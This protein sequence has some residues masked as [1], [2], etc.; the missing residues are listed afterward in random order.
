MWR[1]PDADVA[2]MWAG[3]SP[4]RRRGA[5]GGEPIQPAAPTWGH[6]VVRLQFGDDRLGDACAASPRPVPPVVLTGTPGALRRYSRVLQGH[7]TGTHGY[8]KGAPGG[9][10]R[11]LTGE[12][13]LAARVLVEEQR[14][15]RVRRRRGDG[16][17]LGRHPSHLAQWVWLRK[18]TADKGTKNRNKGTKNRNKGTKNRN[19]V[20][21]NAAYDY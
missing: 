11:V 19:K 15:H 6:L 2:Q 9:T 18:G 16:R 7:S 10:L 12:Q 20:A 17:R 3:V 13:S 1:S 14:R 4:R 21:D 8:S 5:A